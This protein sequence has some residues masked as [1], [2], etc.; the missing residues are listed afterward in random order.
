MTELDL[1]SPSPIAPSPRSPGIPSGRRSPLPVLMCGTFMIVLDFFV[2][3]VALPSMQS[4]LHASTSAIEWVVAGYGLTFAVLLV[5]GGRL[6]DLVRAA[7]G[8]R[9]RA[10]GVRRRLGRL[11]L[12][13]QPPGSWSLPAW[14][15]ASAR[16]LVSPNVL[17]IIGVAFTGPARVRAIT[18]YGLVMGLAAAGGQLIGGILIQADVLGLAWRSVFLI[19]VPVGLAALALTR[20]LVPES[21]VDAAP[22]GDRPWPRNRAWS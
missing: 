19:N 16:A 20:R 3:N 7:A 21:R 22:A 15:R 8:L 5:A 12:G 14:S 6:G 13:A 18:I 9:R 11:R 2:V 17:S 10:R 1:A 4:D